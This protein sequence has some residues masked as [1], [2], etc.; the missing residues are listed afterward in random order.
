MGI[1]DEFESSHYTRRLHTIDMT[2]GN[3][4]EQLRRYAAQ[5]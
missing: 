5:M 4:D 2:W 1:T 3:A